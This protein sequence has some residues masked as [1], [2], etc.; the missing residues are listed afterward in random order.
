M[1]EWG[2]GRRRGE[3]GDVVGAA[4]TWLDRADAVGWAVSGWWIGARSL[5]AAA[6]AVK[7]PHVSGTP[8]RWMARARLRRLTG[9]A[10]GA[11]ES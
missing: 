5:V 10:Q 3:S 9:P 11:G 7:G 6:P 1:T 8:C 2:R 4:A